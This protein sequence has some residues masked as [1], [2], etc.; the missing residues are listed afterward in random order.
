MSTTFSE[1]LMSDPKYQIVQSE[2]IT[3]A[4]GSV[5]ESVAKDL[6]IPDPPEDKAVAQLQEDND[7]NT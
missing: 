3:K 4:T 7:D 5:S 2:L 6:A 1:F